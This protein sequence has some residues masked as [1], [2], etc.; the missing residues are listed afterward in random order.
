MSFRRTLISMISKKAKAQSGANLSTPEASEKTPDQVVQE[1]PVSKAEEPPAPETVEPLSDPAQ[2][3]EEVLEEVSHPET[4]SETEIAP[5][6]L[7]EV[8]ADDSKKKKSKR[9]GKD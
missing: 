6:P 1:E 4:P 3:A 7:E 8:G 9:F 5:E 2:I